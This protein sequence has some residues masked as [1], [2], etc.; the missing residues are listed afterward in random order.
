MAFGMSNTGVRDSGCWLLAAGAA[1]AE[2][3]RLQESEPEKLALQ[4]LPWH[5]GSGRDST[6]TFDI[7]VWHVPKV[8]GWSWSIRCWPFG[9]FTYHNAHPFCSPPTPVPSADDSHYGECKVA[10]H[11]AHSREPS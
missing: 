6:S 4:Q 11:S 8:V 9:D 1:E 5:P 10:L 3:R 2:M 7:D